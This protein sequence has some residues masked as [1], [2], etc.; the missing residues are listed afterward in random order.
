VES[1]PEGFKSVEY[2]SYRGAL[3]K[4]CA[5]QAASNFWPVHDNSREMSSNSR[6]QVLSKYT[7]EQ[8]SKCSSSFV[9]SNPGAS[10]EC[11][12]ASLFNFSA[13]NPPFILEDV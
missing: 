13:L 5:E 12:W 11:R 6:H 4:R 3:A 7:D 10:C 1:C 2:S 9:R 8:R